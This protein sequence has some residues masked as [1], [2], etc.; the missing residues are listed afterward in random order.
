MVFFLS[1]TLTL[2]ET[3]IDIHMPQTLHHLIKRNVKS[4]YSYFNTPRTI[5]YALFQTAS[6]QKSKGIEIIPQHHT[7]T[8][9]RGKKLRVNI[10]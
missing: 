9:T 3:K 10:N 1:H 7:L 8:L 6:M 4:E 5:F 2:P